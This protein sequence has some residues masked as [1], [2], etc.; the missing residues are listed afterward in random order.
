M[1]LFRYSSCESSQRSVP[2]D[3]A[4]TVI[5]WQLLLASLS[6]LRVGGRS[7][8]ATRAVNMRTYKKKAISRDPSPKTHSYLHFKICLS[9][10]LKKI[11]RYQPYAITLSFPSRLWL[12]YF[13]VSRFSPVDLRYSFRVVSFLPLVSVEFSGALQKRQGFYFEQVLDIK[14]ARNAGRGFVLFK[15]AIAKNKYY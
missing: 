4:Q 3:P 1:E 10:V 13:S 5:P 15:V 12:N 9:P 8:P 2:V 11:N 7:V 14:L 6:R